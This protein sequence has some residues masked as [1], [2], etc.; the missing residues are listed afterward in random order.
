[1]KQNVFDKTIE[2]I[3]L[4]A[5]E[6]DNV[7]VSFS[8]WKDSGVMLNLVLDYWRKHYPWRKLWL[9][10][11]DYEAQY[12]S[13]TE[14]VDLMLEKHKDILETYRC[15]LPFAASCATSMH[16]HYWLPWEYEKK[17][18][19]VRQMPSNWINEENHKF[20]FFEKT[21][22]DYD[23][24]D[25]FSKWY[26]KEKQAK[27][28][29]CLVGIRT[30]ESMN[31]WRAIHSD[32]RY[33]MYENLKWSKK[34]YD[35]EEIYNFYPIYD[36]KTSDIWVANGKFNWD[37]N[38][39]YDLFHLAW[40]P[41]SKMR[42]ASPF[43]DAGIENLKLYKVI[44]PHNWAKMLWRV[45][46]VNF[47]WIYGWTTAMWWHSIKLPKWHTWKSYM[48]FLLDTLPKQTK[49]NYLAKLNTSIKFWRE[50]GGC[51]SCET[52][53]KLKEKKIPIEVWDTTNFKTTKKPVKMDY[54][55]DIDI[56]EAK[57]IPTYKRMCICIMKN[58]HLCKY[59]GF[60]LTKNELARRKEAL[61]KYENTYK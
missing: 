37:Y 7:Y 13:T 44:D 58:D 14:Y 34:M 55:D 5:E 51:L 22:W 38:K 11:L 32:N 59:M 19:W 52:I 15:C 6:F 35:E 61:N 47:S 48:Y 26:H 24:Q 27:K 57:E 1:M 50:K 60:S 30:E 33:K 39:L 31:R 21:M 18:I 54:L 23:F 41:L 29:A 40:V 42:V 3:K 25:K 20:D 17:D 9:L 53:Q 46:G 45:D 4:I 10:H 16:Q 43:N 8:W 49:N 56:Q 28:T 36:W 12:A 2:R